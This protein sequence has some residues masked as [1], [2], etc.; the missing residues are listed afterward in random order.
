MCFAHFDNKSITCSSNCFFP[1]FPFTIFRF[2]FLFTRFSF[3]FLWWIWIAFSSKWI[4][5]DPDVGSSICSIS[6]VWLICTMFICRW[7]ACVGGQVRL[8]RRNTRHP[9]ICYIFLLYMYSLSITW[10]FTINWHSVQ[11]MSCLVAKLVGFCV[12]CNWEGTFF[13]NNWHSKYN[14]AEI[15]SSIWQYA[16]CCI[17]RLGGQFD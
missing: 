17:L 16:L 13:F 1:S 3:L 8:L 11:N 6:I 9:Y 12:C 2:S 5:P 4:S 10:L 14:T 7:F 15:R